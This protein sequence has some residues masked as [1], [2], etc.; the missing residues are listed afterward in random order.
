MPSSHVAHQRSSWRRCSLCSPWRGYQNNNGVS[1][2]TYAEED[3]KE[4]SPG[5]ECW[6]YRRL[7]ICCNEKCRAQISESLINTC[8][9]DWEVFNRSNYQSRLRV[10]S[11]ARENTFS[12]WIFCYL[13]QMTRLS[14][15]TW[16]SYKMCRG[17]RFS[18]RWLWCGAVWVL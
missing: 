18:R 3:F 5:N 4:P 13:T 14:Q 8:S 11:I 12:L 15:P 16:S 2:T 7:R 1:A 17:L 10:Q 6:G 9:Y